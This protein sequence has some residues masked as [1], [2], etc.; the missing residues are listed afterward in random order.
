MTHV[1]DQAPAPEQ[2]EEPGLQPLKRDRFA[3]KR[4][5]STLFDGF[6]E[7]GSRVLAFA[8]VL[9]LVA[10]LIVVFIVSFSADGIRFP[11]TKW[12]LD[13]YQSIPGYLW[14]ALGVS[15]LVA[16][17][18][19][20]GALI[21][22]IPLAV[23]L[24]RG[25]LPGREI[26]EVFFRSPLQL[27]QLVLGVALYQYFVFASGLGVSLRGTLAGLLIGHIVIIVPYLL[28][29]SVGR[30]SQLD[31]TIEDAAQGLGAGFLR[32][33]WSITLP[34]LRP[35]LVAGSF[36]AFLVS[37]ND[38][39]LSVFLVGAG[40][41]TLPV[42]MLA[43]AEVSPGVYLYAISGV[44]VVL[45]IAASVIVDRLVGLRSVVGGAR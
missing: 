11:P 41:T 5:L 32:V 42:V 4:M 14:D 20:L 25:S 38:V 39:A 45:S 8:V 33:L 12:G 16:A 1:M 17:C 2:T 3:E 28:T 30:L 31:A 40:T 7:V 18:S 6:Y 15:A 23:A 34:L 9:F 36:L 43:D 19:V 29:A 22:T 21:I 13:G 10:P 37:F 26:F 44:V 35:G 24:V 27:P